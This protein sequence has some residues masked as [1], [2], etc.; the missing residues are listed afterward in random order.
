G[1]SDRLGRAL[2]QVTTSG[3]AWGAAW[4]SAGEL[5]R[6]ILYL[7]SL[8]RRGA[9][10]SGLTVVVDARKQLPAPALFCALR[11]AQSTSPGCIHTVLLLAEKELAAHRERLPGVQVETLGSLRALGRFVDS[12][13]LP[14]ELEGSFPYC[15]GEWVQFFQVS[16]ST[17]RAPTSPPCCWPRSCQVS[18]QVR[19]VPHLPPQDVAACIQ[20]HQALMG[21]VLSD[22]QLL[23]LQR[24]G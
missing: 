8:P 23:Q 15:H 7:C 5:A 21:R 6:L 2:L 18:P 24:E 3:S 14:P 22:P 1:S 13:Q 12:S 19:P 11:S 10:D 9:K 20:R 17:Q 4:C 16:V